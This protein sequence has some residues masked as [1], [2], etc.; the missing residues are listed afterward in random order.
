MRFEAVTRLVADLLT[1]TH[2]APAPMRSSRTTR[3]MGRPIRFANDA[4]RFALSEATDGAA[5]GRSIVF[6]VIVGTGTGGC[7]VIDGRVV[8]GV[9]AIAG[10]WGHNPLPA[11]LAEEVPGPPC[12]CGRTGCIE[13]FL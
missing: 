2:D 7:M 5:A 3:R 13:T 1:C 11:P 8:T 12:Y 10:E 6:G 4:N 9:N